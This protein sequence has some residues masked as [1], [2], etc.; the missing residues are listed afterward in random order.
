ML[1]P[2]TNWLPINRMAW[3]SA[4]RTTGSELP[5]NSRPKAAAGPR[6]VELSSWISLPVSIRPQV[7][8]LTNTR[9]LLPRWAAQSASRSLSAISASAV[10]WSG[11]R[12]SDSARHISSTPS[13]EDKS[14]SCIRASSDDWSRLRA[15]TPR[16][17]SPAAA[18]MATA[19]SSGRAARAS[20]VST[21]PDLSAR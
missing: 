1:R 21:T 7:E 19:S 14:Y 16:T 2:I 20:R 17:S 5:D 18:Q 10:S 12:S 8:A 3:R 4:P 13:S 6:V 15:R 11:M 9:S